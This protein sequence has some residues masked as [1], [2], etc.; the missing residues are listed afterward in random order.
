[1]PVRLIVH[2]ACRESPCL[3]QE[4][5]FIGFRYGI[6]AALKISENEKLFLIFADF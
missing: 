4:I 6:F 1:M 3:V 2:L 5:F